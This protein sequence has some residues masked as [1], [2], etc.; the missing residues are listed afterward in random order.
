[1]EWYDKEDNI[2]EDC[3][4]SLTHTNHFDIEN[5]LMKSH[6]N[7]DFEIQID[8]LVYENISNHKPILSFIQKENSRKE[9]INSKVTEEKIFQIKKVKRRRKSKDQ[10]NS[11]LNTD[12]KAQM[13]N[14]PFLNTNLSLDNAKTENST[15]KN[16][17]IEQYSTG[18]DQECAELSSQTTNQE[19]PDNESLINNNSCIIEMKRNLNNC[20]GQ[21]YYIPLNQLSISERMKI[22]KEKAKQLLEKKTKRDSFCFSVNLTTHDTHSPT[23]RESKSESNFQD[24][25]MSSNIHNETFSNN[26][27]SKKESK[28]L[29]NRVSAQRSR[30]RKKKEYDDLK[31]IA[32]KLMDE[33]LKLKKQI[34]HRDNQISEIKHNMD[35]L[36]KSCEQYVKVNIHDRENECI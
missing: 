20:E 11:K 28:M 7:N 24:S 22:K 34:E 29:R 15:D 2:F 30:D 5:F 18:N 12:I 9:E 4:E 33:N 1:M 21:Y 25:S 3:N 35:K 36:C 32:Q 23:N 10:I 31:V 6:N 17:L 8:D 19:F 27:L 13:S 14:H 16:T 26:Y